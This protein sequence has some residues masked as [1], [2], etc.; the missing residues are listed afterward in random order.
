MFKQIHLYLKEKRLS[1]YDF[2]LI[3]IVSD[4]IDITLRIIKG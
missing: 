4:I 1:G 3:I 2:I